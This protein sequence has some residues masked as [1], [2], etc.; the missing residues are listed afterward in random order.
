MYYIYKTTN[1]V[2]NKIYVGIHKSNDIEYEC[3]F[4]AY[5][6]EAEIVDEIFIARL[7]TYNINVGGHG[8]WKYVNVNNVFNSSYP[9]FVESRQLGARKTEI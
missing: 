5:K 3:E 2:N 9:G 8:S 6:K 4:D 7:D 1:R